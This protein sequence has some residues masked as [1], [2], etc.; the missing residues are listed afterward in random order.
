MAKAT[1]AKTKPTTTT[2]KKV[3]KKPSTVSKR[4][5]TKKAAAKTQQPPFFQI[6]VTDQT[7]YWLIFGT[8]SIL[9]AMWVYTLD[10]RVRD[11]YD[12]IDINT[13]SADSMIRP[14]VKKDEPAASE[15]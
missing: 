4:V 7:L 3:T 6:R 8:V 12:Q 13:Y 1:K 10:A 5:S 2:A 14:E 11:L 15:Q 9:F